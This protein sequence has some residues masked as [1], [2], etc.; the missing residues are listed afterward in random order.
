MIISSFQTSSPTIIS[1]DHHQHT[2]DTEHFCARVIHQTTK[3][4]ITQYKR[5]KNDLAI[6][7]TW[8]TAFGKE[9][10]NLAQ[11]DHKTGTKG[12]SS[13]F[14]MT[15][16]EIGQFS[17]DRTITYA[18][19]VVNYHPQKANPTTSASWSAAIFSTTHVNLPPE[20]LI[21][22]CPKFYGTVSSLLKMQNSWALTSKT[23][24]G[25]P[26][27]INTNVCPITCVPGSHYL[28]I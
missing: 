6:S 14:L 8:T 18:W 24:T 3:E 22:L 5:L 1:H 11:S 7:D 16:A 23:F 2:P 10:S 19:V 20:W 9:F 4:T 26:H 27:W 12:T 17:K 13:I 25:A 15:H 28:T 21:S